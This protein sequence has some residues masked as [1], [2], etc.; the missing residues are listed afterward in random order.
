MAM[1]VSVNR[2]NGDR[3]KMF[4]FQYLLFVL[5]ADYKVQLFQ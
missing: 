3:K 2:D 4:H 1:I 5:I